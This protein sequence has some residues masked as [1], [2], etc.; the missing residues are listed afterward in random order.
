MTIGTLSDVFADVAIFLGKQSEL[1]VQNSP[2]DPSTIGMGLVL[3]ALLSE[4]DA[5]SSFLTKDAYQE[6]KQSTEGVF[7]GLGVLVGIENRILTVIRPIPGSPALRAGI[8]DRD[9]IISIDDQDTYGHTLDEMV[10]FMRGDP[11]TVAKI[12]VLSPSSLA[13]KYVN[14]NRE[15]IKVDSVTQSEWKGRNGT[16]LRI[17]IESFS[18]RT[19]REVREALTR[20]REKE[21]GRFKGV[22]LDLRNNPG[23]LLDQA[24]QVADAFLPGGTIVSTRGRRSEAQSATEGPEKTGYPMVV[25]I[26]GDSASASEIVAGALKENGRAVIIGQP[27]FGKGSV[28]TVFELPVERALKLTI[29]RYFTPNGTSIQGRGIIPDIWLQPVFSGDSNKNLLGTYRYR[30]EQFLH[31]SLVAENERSAKH[32]SP[33]QR[34][35]YLTD[36]RQDDLVSAGPAD[37]ELSVAMSLLDI[38]GATFETRLAPGRQRASHWLALT[39]SQLQKRLEAA[40]QKA[41]NWLASKLNVNWPKSVQSFHDAGLELA[42][43]ELQ[44]FTFRP[45]QNV[46]FHYQIS[47]LQPFPVEHVSFFVTPDGG[48]LNSQ[49]TLIGTIGGN[50]QLVGNAAWEIPPYAQP[51]TVT[52]RVGLAVDGMPVAIE[53]KPLILSVVKPPAT[54]I[55]FVAQLADEIGGREVG[56]LESREKAKIKITVK[57]EG[58]IEIRKLRVNVANLGGKQIKLGASHVEIEALSPGDSSTVTLD[59][60][61]GNS[62]ISEKMGVGVS[63]D[64]DDLQRPVAETYYIYGRPVIGAPISRLSH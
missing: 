9:Q 37:Y 48:A 30:S 40:S 1:N 32:L 12:L 43:A 15:V 26:N 44:G 61:A 18:S 52:A 63:I 7:G 38:V 51:G 50:S 58:A 64:S 5:H 3:N 60:S 49:E 36:A 21:K 55:S 35:Y 23:G 39:Q 22:V 57:N 29:A 46:V 14:I 11:G 27:S 6:L 2:E 8:K 4:L 13:P 16:Y 56:V 54:K 42:L 59:V 19:G 31:K 24:V 41:S 47:N 20:F 25:L 28:Q 34:G 53:R 45:A 17:A 62:V 33:S 10:E